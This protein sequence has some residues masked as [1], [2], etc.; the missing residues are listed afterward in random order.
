MSACCGFCR[1]CL[2]SGIGHQS[3]TD[4]RFYRRQNTQRCLHIRPDEFYWQSMQRGRSHGRPVFVS[5]ENRRVIFFLKSLTLYIIVPLNTTNPD[6]SSNYRHC[7]T[8]PN[9]YRDVMVYN[10]TIPS[11]LA[12]IAVISLPYGGRPSLSELS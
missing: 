12:F 7:D 4:H 9:Y 6:T 8:C 11:C 5:T 10:W 1:Y 2:F 3:S